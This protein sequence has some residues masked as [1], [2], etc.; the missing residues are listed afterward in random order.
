[1]KGRGQLGRPRYKWKGNV[2]M[3]FKGTEYEGMDWFYLSQDSVWRRV[4]VKTVMYLA[5]A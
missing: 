5:V 3:E 4:F 1:L 2:N